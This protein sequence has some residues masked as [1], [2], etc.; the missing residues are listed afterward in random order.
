MCYCNEHKFSELQVRRLEQNTA[1]NA[2]TEQFITAKIPGNALKQES[3]THS[4]LHQPSSHSD[5]GT[6]PGFK[7]SRGKSIWGGV[8]LFLLYVL[9]KISGY[10]EIWEK[11]PP[12]DYRPEFT[13]AKSAH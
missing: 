13:T 8:I 3:R 7:L 5:T 11:S 12:R 1:L 10:N 9:K 6:Q 2:Q 4:V